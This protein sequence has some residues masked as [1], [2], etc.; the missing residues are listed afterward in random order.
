MQQLAI[1]VL[2][3]DAQVLILVSQIIVAG[4]P[5]LVLNARL[6]VARILVSQIIVAKP[7]QLVLNA[8]LGVA[9][10]LATKEAAVVHR[11]MQVHA[12]NVLQQYQNPLITTK[13]FAP[14][15]TPLPQA[16]TTVQ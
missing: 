4:P 1:N 13:I 10:I 15:R 14:T 7:P 9:Q 6:G 5:Q 2:P 16:R 11:E 3:L 8:R 12:L